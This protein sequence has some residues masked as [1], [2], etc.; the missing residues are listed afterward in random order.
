MPPAR[1]GQSGPSSLP[2]PCSGRSRM[3]SRATAVERLIEAAPSSRSHG[4]RRGRPRHADVLAGSTSPLTAGATDPRL[5]NRRPRTERPSPSS[6]RF[7]PRPEG[8]PG[9]CGTPMFAGWFAPRNMVWP[10]P[11]PARPGD[12]LQAHA[13]WADRWRLFGTF[14]KAACPT[15]S[16]I[17]AD[18]NQSAHH[19]SL[20]GTGGE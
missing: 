1:C 12:A 16:R 5:C 2:K 13:S 10:R 7:N 8:R 4:A 6:C 19:F 18:S 9:S 11:P 3:R 17:A 15:E 14:Q 20:C